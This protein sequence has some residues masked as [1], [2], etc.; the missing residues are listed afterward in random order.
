MTAKF[1]TLLARTALIGAA[2]LSLAGCISFG[3]KPPPTL[4][5]LHAITPVAAGAVRT[6]DDAHAVNVM[7]PSAPPTLVTQRVMVQAGPNSIAYL[8]DALWAATPAVLMRGLLAETIEAKTGRFVPETRFTGIQ[9]DLRLSGSLV[10]FGLDGP[11]KAVIVTY[12]GNI[13]RSGSDRIETRRFTARV[14]VSSEEPQIVGMALDQ[15][16][17]QVAGE[18][19]DWIGSH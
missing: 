10:A 8:K 5:S 11:G 12:D 18:V 1:A 9:P 6:S 7:M 17:N 2:S 15:A 4:M 13:A 14:P 3:P 19:A 16:A